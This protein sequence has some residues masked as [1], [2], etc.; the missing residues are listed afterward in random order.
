MTIPYTY[1][2]PW[3]KS[4]NTNLF[5]VE[6]KQLAAFDDI[7]AW[8]QV[9]CPRLSI[10]WGHFFSKVCFDAF[11]GSISWTL[12]AVVDPIVGAAAGWMILEH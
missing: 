9:A 4:D 6:Q 11:K 1:I 5:D 8:I 12:C 3:L 10:D 7:E 2:L